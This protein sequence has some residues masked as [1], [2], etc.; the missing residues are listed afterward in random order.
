SMIEAAL[1]DGYLRSYPAGLGGLGGFR[2]LRGYGR[3]ACTRRIRVGN[4]NLWS[5]TEKLFEIC[6]VL[7]RHKVDIACF[8]ETK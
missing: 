6:D 7:G 5:F 2:G 4:W 1:C 8:Q 3:A